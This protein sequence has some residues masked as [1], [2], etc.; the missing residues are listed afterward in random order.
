[1]NKIPFQINNNSFEQHLGTTTA[2]ASALKYVIQRIRSG[3]GYG[4][5]SLIALRLSYST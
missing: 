5:W 2:W 1:M 4:P 3:M